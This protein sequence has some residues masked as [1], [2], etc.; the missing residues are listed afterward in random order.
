[1][2][3]IYRLYLELLKKYG[4]P[5]PW[6]WKDG[7]EPSTPLEICLGAILTQ[8]TN[9]QN[10]EKAL[11][12]LKKA[13]AVSVE[14]IAAIPGRKLE[15]YLRPSGFYRQKAER[16]KNFCRY[17][18]E[19]Y[20]GKL[21]KLFQ[22]EAKD[23]REELLSLKGIGP[24]TADTILLYAAKKPIFVIDEYTRRFVK[25]HGLGGNLSYEA[26]QKLFMKNLPKS[27]KIYEDYHALIVRD[28]K[29]DGKIS[30]R[31]PKT[32]RKISKGIS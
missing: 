1:M 6:P 3:K 11:T 15:K 2:T 26:L 21:E 19:N 22:K 14:K 27:V 28:G 5:K 12:N 4:Q 31:G 24:E 10:V 23:L 17:L 16:L 25:R 32:K 9:W 7:M 8:N 18:V 13:K 30:G 29:I 20:G